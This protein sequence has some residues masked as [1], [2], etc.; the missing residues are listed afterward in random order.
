MRPKK[1]QPPRR[2]PR[3]TKREDILEAGTKIFLER[4]FGATSM[5]EV[6][7]QANVSKRTVYDYFE[8]KEGLFA[9]VVQELC[10]RITPP[11]FLAKET[12]ENIED[13]LKRFGEWFLTCIYS[14]EQ[15]N[16]FQTVINDSR[17]F[18]EIG[19]MMFS[20]PVRRTQDAVAA[21]FAVQVRKGRLQLKDTS[22]AA[23]LFIAMLKGDTHMK[24]LFG[25]SRG[26]LQ[27]EIR[28]NAFTTVK[29]FM[30][31]ARKN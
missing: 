7:V 22:T 30:D 20:G 1:S 8:S 2:G 16:L 14:V 29:L 21:Y 6:A 18:P 5:D 12:E 17:Q 25:Q 27:K 19:D 9:A 10:E 15:I 24:L 31:G 4:G 28:R 11:E 3:A 26:I 13:V 23:A